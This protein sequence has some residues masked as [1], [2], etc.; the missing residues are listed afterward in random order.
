MQ[1]RRGSPEHPQ[2][3]GFIA[4]IHTKASQP[5]LNGTIH[6]DG[7]T[8][9]ACGRVFY[10]HPHCRLDCKDE[11]CSTPLGRAGA[12]Q[13]EVGSGCASHDRNLGLGGMPQRAQGLTAKAQARRLVGVIV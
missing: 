3:H 9:L 10:G 5:T 4:A 1:A 12:K 6:T 11:K 13:P 8:A 7:G 2:G